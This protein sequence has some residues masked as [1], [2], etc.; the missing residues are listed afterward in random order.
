MRRL[1]P[2][3]WRVC[4]SARR[5]G[6]RSTRESP[7]DQLSPH[8]LW[9]GRGGEGRDYRRVVGAGIR[10]LVHLAEEEAPD[11]PPRDL[12]YCRSARRGGRQSGRVARPGRQHGGRSAPAPGA[13]PA[14]WRRGEQSD[15]DDGRRRPLAELRG[16]AREVLEG[17]RAAASL[18]RD[19][20]P[21]GRGEG[22]ARPEGQAGAE[23]LTGGLARPE[24]GHPLRRGTAPLSVRPICRSRCRA[25]GRAWNDRADPTAA[26]H[27]SLCR[28]HVPPPV[29]QGRGGAQGG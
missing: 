23:A 10:A 8:A 29:G 14:L 1:R 12:I 16:D 25:A 22:D 26:R 7:M 13:D 20:G 21:L 18:R 2:A 17:G 4:P 6:S 24:I 19:T 3:R 15:P 5:A 27:E 11:R 9:L 28:S